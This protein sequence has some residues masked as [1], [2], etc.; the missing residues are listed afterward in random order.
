MR[1]EHVDWLRFVS[2][3]KDL[4]KTIESKWPVLLHKKYRNTSS[5]NSNIT[6]EQDGPERDDRQICE[7]CEEDTAWGQEHTGCRANPATCTNEEYRAGVD[8]PDYVEHCSCQVC[9]CG[10]ESC[11]ASDIS[12]ITE[13]GER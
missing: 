10:C 3:A 6:E 9:F 1:D 13:K 12:T 2:K 5:D 8:C 7:T 11:T 4:S